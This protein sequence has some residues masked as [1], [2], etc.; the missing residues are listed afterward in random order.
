[1][2]PRPTSAEIIPDEDFTGKTIGGMTVICKI[3]HGGMGTVWKAHDESLN[4]EVAIKVLSRHLFSNEQAYKRFLVEAQSAARIASKNVVTVYIAGKQ[5]DLPY[6]VMEFVDGESSGKILQ[7]QGRLH[8]KQAVDFVKQA[9]QGLSDAHELGVIHRDV[10]PDNLLL[11]S[12]GV[13]KVADFGLARLNYMEGDRLTVFGQ[14]MG[15]PHYMAPEQAQGKHCDHRCDIYSLGAVFYRFL[16]GD[17]LFDAETAIS[18]MMQHASAPTPDITLRD[19]SVPRE[20][21]DILD[22]MLKKQPEERFQSCQEVIAA[23]NAT[24]DVLRQR[25]ATPTPLPSVQPAGNLIMVV[26]DSDIIRNVLGK[27]LTAKGYRVV[28]A[29]DGQDALEKLVVHEPQLIIL[30]IS[31]PRMNGLDCLD[32]LKNRSGTKDIEVI[33]CT[34]EGEKNNVLRALKAG[35]RDYVLKPFKVDAVVDRIERVLNKRTNTP[36]T[37]PP[38]KR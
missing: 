25:E 4:R 14:V 20:I 13:I 9:A 31:M 23:L 38:E 28:E 16:T 22:K 27:A 8:L 33:M 21:K 6:I 30:D 36:F 15:S 37:P 34:T 7:R 17:Y 32:H 29:C 5:G 10:K 35:A 12:R 2:S 11:N 24:N 19:R 26:D 3:G 18:I 1:M